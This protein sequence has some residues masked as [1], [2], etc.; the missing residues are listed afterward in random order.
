MSKY[1]IVFVVAAG[2]LQ[3]VFS[4]AQ[5]SDEAQT[6]WTSISG[7]EAFAEPIPKL[8]VRGAF[9]ELDAIADRERDAFMRT[10]QAPWRLGWFYDSLQRAGDQRDAAP[11]FDFSEQLL[12]WMDVRPE[13]IAAHVAYT[14]FLVERAWDERGGKVA[15]LVTDEGWAGFEKYLR[16]AQDAAN[17]AIALGKTD[18]E[19]HVQRLRIARHL[20]DDAAAERVFDQ[21]VKTS[22]PYYRLFQHRARFLFPKWGGAQDGT[23]MRE[24]QQ[25]ALALTRDNQKTTMNL[26]FA[27]WLIRAELVKAA[28]IVGITWEEVQT[29]YADAVEFADDDAEPFYLNLVCWLACNYEQQ[30][31]AKTYFAEM[32]G[33]HW[34]HVWS[35]SKL[36]MWYAWVEGDGPMPKLN[37]IHEAVWNGYPSGLRAAL[38]QAE[39]GEIDAGD[40]YGRTPLFVAVF[41]DWPT[42]VAI[43]LD[44]GADPNILT[45]SNESPLVMAAQRGHLD[46]CRLLLAGGADPT[47]EYYKGASAIHFAVQAGKIEIARALLDAEPALIHAMGD[48]RTPLH[49]AV[50]AGHTDVIRL[51]IEREADINARGRNNATP[52][53]VAAYTNQIA[54]AKLLLEYKPDLDAFDDKGWTPLHAATDSDLLEFAKLLVGAGAN[55]NHP[56]KGKVTPMVV[57]VRSRQAATLAYLLSLDD[58]DISAQDERGQTLLHLA[59]ALGAVDEAKVLLEGGIDTSLKDSKD[60]TALDLAVRYKRDEI[61]QLLD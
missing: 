60:R 50:G 29:A 24:F 21:S 14:R 25:R 49:F 7:Y 5:E 3:G 22:P 1:S 6:T 10:G 9:A 11:L 57:A 4:A 33:K 61:I 20:E 51:L 30:A 32:G 16:E 52:L 15:D 53:I 56:G 19:L 8:F 40:E 23:D 28:H 47:T 31:A 54:A 46:N 42:A 12:K 17:N 36:R 18:P 44:A 39:P 35:E 58:V 48:E 13:S 41:R 59:A 45:P 27:E 38:Q 26:L 43:L 2:L 37:H 55:P 34:S